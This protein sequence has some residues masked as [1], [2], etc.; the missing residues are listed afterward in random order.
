MY[1]KIMVPVDLAHIE[2][3]EPALETVADLARH[4][5]A[6][7]CYVG[8]TSNTPSS[9]AR[10]P[11][12]F[13][14][15]LDAFAEKRSKVH[16]QPVSTHTI[17]SPDPIA[18]LDD[19]LIKA[20]DDVGADLIVMPTHPPR[21]LDVIMPSHGGKIATHTKASVFLVRP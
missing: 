12:E 14:R 21:H 20:I 10:T 5:D 11:E 13:T 9:V 16:G 1:K 7:V 4:Y 2:V 18:D 6:E 3:I 8:V 17:A 15:K 19:E